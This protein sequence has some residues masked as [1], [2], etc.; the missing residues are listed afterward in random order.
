[1]D[2]SI[3]RRCL[4]MAGLLIASMGSAQAVPIPG[5]FATGVDGAGNALPAGSND[6][7][8][9]VVLTSQPAVVIRDAIPVTWV[10]NTGSYRWVWQTVN[11]TP[12]NVIRTLRTTF[13]L[14]GLD[15]AS[16]LISGQWATDNTGLDILINGVSTGNT[17]GG[18]SSL[19]SFS[20]TSGFISGINTLDFRV[21]DVG[22]ISISGLL[23]T[24][25]SGT[26]NVAGDNGGGQIPEPASLAILGFGLAGLGLV[27]RR[28]RV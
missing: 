17:C 19:C 5:L 3:L 6:P 23:V 27:R 4:L 28:R 2:L 25:I 12:T 10:P 13:D 26:A 24:S 18:F 8:Y 14:T 20:I 22:I 15:P 16:A 11:G 1:M 7:H 21:R 9:T